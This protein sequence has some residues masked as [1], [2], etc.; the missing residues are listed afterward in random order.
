[1][2]V[3]IS[4]SG[5]L[6]QS[7]A[8]ALRE[9]LPAVIQTVEPYVSSEDIEKG[10]RWG[11]EISLELE[12]SDFGILCITPTNTGAAWLNFEAGALSKSID[13]SRVVPFLFRLERADLPQGPL[14]Q[15]Q[16]V[17][18]QKDDVRKMVLALNA[19]GGERALE[20]ARL[21]GFFEIWWPQLESALASIDS[22]T[23]PIA[24]AQRSD[25]DLLSEVLEIVRRQQQTLNTP[26]ML[27]PPE[28]VEAVVANARLSIEGNV[29]PTALR[30]LRRGWSHLLA[31]VAEGSAPPAVIEAVREMREPLNYMF[32][33]AR[34]R[35]PRYAGAE[36]ITPTHDERG[37]QQRESE[38]D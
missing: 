36:L 30:E 2:K 33:R 13:Q 6:S 5:S 32:R 31:A 37:S 22:E 24:S 19:A 28:Y 9:W 23:P 16:S 38:D 7:V 15:F 12:A 20:E 34:I 21:E 10:A 27:L 4:W 14:V 11:S 3:F 1:M 25:E 35:L 18:A 8:L 29:T 17:L 26:E